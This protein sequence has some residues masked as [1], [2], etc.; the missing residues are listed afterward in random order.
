MINLS[1]FTST[2]YLF[3][4]MKVRFL[5]DSFS[6]ISKCLIALFMLSLYPAN[7][8]AQTG[9]ATNSPEA[10]LDIQSTN[11]G[12]LMPRIALLSATD[13]TSVINPN[14]GALEV[15]TMVYNTTEGRKGMVA[16]DVEVID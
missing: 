11:A 1:T 4:N 8:F 16:V 7:I 13:A 2:I 9:I 10:A 5:R 15:S 14:G 3:L 6:L 12:L